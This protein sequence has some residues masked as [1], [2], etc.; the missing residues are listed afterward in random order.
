MRDSL[1]YTV[2]VYPDLQSGESLLYRQ[3]F[4]VDKLINI[5]NK[6][7]SLVPES[8]QETIPLSN[9]SGRV[10]RLF[11]F[12][13]VLS[14]FSATVDSFSC[15]HGRVICSGSTTPQ[16]NTRPLYYITCGSKTYLGS[17]AYAL[18]PDGSIRRPYVCDEA[19]GTRPTF[20]LLGFFE[21]GSCQSLISANYLH[22]LC[23]ELTDIPSFIP[24]VLPSDNPSQLPSIL[25][26][27]SLQPT[28]TS[29]LN[30]LLIPL[31]VYPDVDLNG[32]CISNE[33]IQV[34]SGAAAAKTIV[35][36]NPNN[37]PIYS[38]TEH[39]S[40]YDSCI[41]YLRSHGV[42]VIGYIH[43]KVFKFILQYL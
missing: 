17:D 35:I 34:A 36:V 19:F 27:I 43:T 9:N 15:G 2:S 4:V 32:N 37:G 41:S 5:D 11:S 39:K 8:Y 10:V 16:E 1:L 23:S 22:S 21:E 20:N 3:Y 40:S 24:S 13:N 18:S 7:A 26:S 6:A 31:Y 42:E 12:D 14:L 29:P 33:Y 25:P 28:D 30:G 38:S